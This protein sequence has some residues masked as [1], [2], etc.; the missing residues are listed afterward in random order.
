M[1]TLPLFEERP[2]EQGLRLAGKLRGLAEDGI[3]IGTSSWKYPGWLGQ[4]YTRERYLVRGRFSQKKFEA[5]CLQEYA[6][7][8][9]IVC[10]DFSFYQFPP[11]DYWKR[12]FGSA[13]ETLRFGFK[14]PEEI[15]RKDFPARERYGNRAGVS[16]PS[17]LN[18]TLF[19][20]SFLEFLRPYGTRVAMVIL[21][22]GT[23]SRRS[24]ETPAVFFEDLDRFLGALP[25]DFRYSVE[26]RNRE[27]LRPEFF[28]CLSTHSVAHV[29]NS[30]SR[31]PDLTQQLQMPGVFTTDFTVVRALLRPGRSYAQA[32]ARF[33]PYE[34][35]QEPV[36]SAREG[37][38][39]I[40]ERARRERE[41]AYVFV[42]NRLEGNAPGT[43]EAVLET[44]EAT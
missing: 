19:E 41:S 8:F 30:W 1:F 37:I 4:I 32:V 23:F 25:R 5:E 21:E 22:F 27:F 15:T 33:A 29:F 14:V 43:I 42:N 38:R 31:M 35:V 11:E 36:P 7:T 20:E 6:R 17:Y 18:A 39:E 44:E 40:I 3:W 12:L 34:R 10:G 13:P 28:A 9:P 24:Y 26:L 2:P 16:N